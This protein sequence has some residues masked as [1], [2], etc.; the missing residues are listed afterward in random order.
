[1]LTILYD[2]IVE[3]RHDAEPMNPVLVRERIERAL[4]REFN[5]DAWYVAVRFRS[6]YSPRVQQ[7][8]IPE[9]SAR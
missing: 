1:M 6:T 7:P 3:F 2:A 4:R 8:F 5:T 9:R